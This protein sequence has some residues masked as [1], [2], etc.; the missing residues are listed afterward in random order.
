MLLSES[1]RNQS[2]W[3]AS[4]TP[5]S[6]NRLFRRC[7][8]VLIQT[9][10]SGLL[11]FACATARSFSRRNHLHRREPCRGRVRQYQPSGH[12]QHT[13]HVPHVRRSQLLRRQRH[14]HVSAAVSLGAAAAV[15]QR[16]AQHERA[17]PHEHVRQLRHVSGRIRHTRPT[18]LRPLL[19]QHQQHAKRPGPRDRHG[20]RAALGVCRLLVARRHAVQEQRPCDFQSD[21]RTQFHAHRAMARRRERC[22]HVHPRHRGHESHPRARQRVHRRA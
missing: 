14:E 7:V 21:E 22:H 5:I 3:E 2:L 20:R 4:P 1:L 11:A 12:L 10:V 19:P 8:A 17:Q 16:R 6:G 15:G 9:G 18:Q 13:L